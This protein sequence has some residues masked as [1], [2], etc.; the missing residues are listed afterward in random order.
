MKKNVTA[1]LLLAG[2]AA[3]ACGKL[4]IQVKKDAKN[5]SLQSAPASAQSTDSFSL[6]NAE[7]FLSDLD[8]LRTNAA[9]IIVKQLASQDYVGKFRSGMRNYRTFLLE[10]SQKSVTLSDSF[11]TDAAQ[12][13]RS[14]GLSLNIDKDNQVLGMI[15]QTALLAQIGEANVGKLNAGLTKEIQALVQFITIELGVEI[16]GTSSVDKEGDVDVSRGQVTIKLLPI[17]GENIDEATKQADANSILTL[18]FERHL[19][20]NKVGTF[21]ADLRL[22]SGKADPAVA[23]FDISR[24]KESDH[25]SHV[26]SVKM[27]SLTQPANYSRKIIVSDIPGEPKKFNFTDIL[28]ADLANESSH[29]TIVDVN[30]GTQCKI[31]DAPNGDVDDGK[32][33]DKVDVEPTPTP[34]P[35][36]TSNPSQTP[37]QS[38]K[39]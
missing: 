24:T 1:M 13:C 33:D 5:S 4:T 23:T 22:D 6:A 28:N 17:A 7:D 19:G 14:N 31:S 15:L 3:S 26:A 10:K 20:E 16:L 30:K 8:N 34:S 27:G 37:T 12:E 32:N 21:H 25:Y 2:L 38:P 9:E 39:K 18:N 36:P 11:Y 29:K 35:T